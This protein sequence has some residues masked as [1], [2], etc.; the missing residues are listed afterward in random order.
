MRRRDPIL[1]GVLAALAFSLFII[2]VMPS[3]DS[4][5]LS[6]PYWNGMT[7]LRQDFRPVQLSNMQ[8]LTL[9]YPFADNYALLLIGPTLSYSQQDASYISNFLSKG[10]EVIIA[11]DFGTGNQI[12]Q[13]LGLKSRFSGILLVDPLYNIKAEQLPIITQVNLTGVRAIAFNYA[14]YL[15]L[16][17]SAKVLAYSSPFSFG[18]IS[19]IG[20]YSPQDPQG[21]LP[22]MVEIQYGKGQ[23]ILIADS[24][25]YL[26]SMINQQ[27]NMA[28]L[29]T[30]LQGRNAVID[31]SHWVYSTPAQAK[32]LLFSAYEQVN[33][34]G[35]KYD[36][37]AT[38]FLVIL[39]Y[40]GKK[41]PGVREEISRILREHPDWD[42]D[43]VKQ[44]YEERRAVRQ[45]RR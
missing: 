25:L 16:S 24:S 2:A 20:K 17:D 7:I 40:K 5:S 34:L 38:I 28:S 27:D 18:D 23:I 42:G 10:G 8:N 14:T 37:A 6:N 29:S 4:Y 1:L 15:N 35:I 33:S 13:L 36:L 44:L 19:G 43:S 22:V 21:P 3:T 11:D 39:L 26:N 41:V 31:T 9:L 45:E 30:L 12:L 32:L